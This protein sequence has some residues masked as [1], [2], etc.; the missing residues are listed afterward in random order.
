MEK[1]TKVEERQQKKDDRFCFQVSKNLMRRG[2]HL[3]YGPN[4]VISPSL[5]KNKK[6][7][8]SIFQVAFQD[9]LQISPNIFE[10]TVLGDQDLK[11]PVQNKEKSASRKKNTIGL[12]KVNFGLGDE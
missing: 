2:H 8:Y 11:L 6:H 5:T 9:F 3:I 12:V 1:E 7:D 10:K 4:F